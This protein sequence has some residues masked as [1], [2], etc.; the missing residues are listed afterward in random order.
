MW[1]A[2]AVR[3]L[4]KRMAEIEKLSTQI[5]E[6]KVEYVVIT[7][8]VEQIQE[9]IVEM[10][11]V[12][13]EEKIA[14][15]VDGVVKVPVEQIHEQIVAMP[16]DR[17][18]VRIAEGEAKLQDEHKKSE[19]SGGGKMTMGQMKK[20]DEMDI[21]KPQNQYVDEEVHIP[22]AKHVLLPHVQ[23]VQKTVEVPQS[24]TVEKICRR[25]R[26]EAG[27]GSACSGG[28]KGRRGLRNSIRREGR[29]GVDQAVPRL[30][31]RS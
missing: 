31:V 5:S 23:N 4:Q 21:T 26:S 9:Q 14:K 24:D 8:P 11:T 22:I 6:R 7:V 15:V 19:S 17:V 1:L 28:A 27:A 25:L 13:V 3:L 16:T 20:D 10:P 18:E 12:R 30:S 29:G 2:G